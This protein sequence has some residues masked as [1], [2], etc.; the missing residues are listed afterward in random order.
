MTSGQFLRE[1]RNN[2]N[3]SLRQLS[4]KAGVSHTQIADVEKGV[5]F[6][7]KEKLDKILSAL[8]ATTNEIEKFYKLQN[9]EKTPSGVIVEL[10]ELKKENDNL[11][12]KLQ[13]YENNLIIHHNHNTGNQILGTNM[14]DVN[15]N[16]S[17]SKSAPDDL[18]ISELSEDKLQD[19]KKFIK[20]LKNS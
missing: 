18:D 2:K 1:I 10:K 6:G 11:E 8:K 19:L 13:E 12:Q 20:Y 14:R 16:V 15:I 3:F 4:I 9:Y 7:T 17:A 5:N